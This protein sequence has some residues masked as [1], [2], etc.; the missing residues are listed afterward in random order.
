M[1]GGGGETAR[2]ERR[3]NGD[4]HNQRAHPHADRLRGA[5]G[6]RRGDRNPWRRLEEGEK[7]GKKRGKRGKE[8]EQLSLKQGREEKRKTTRGRQGQT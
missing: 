7:R 4:S 5:G 1:G 3:T 6:E 8:T 2:L